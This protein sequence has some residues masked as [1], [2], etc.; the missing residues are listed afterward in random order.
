MV[1]ELDGSNMVDGL[2]KGLHGKS[3][4]DTVLFGKI[5]MVNE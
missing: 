2:G 5:A 3:G 1:N 4:R